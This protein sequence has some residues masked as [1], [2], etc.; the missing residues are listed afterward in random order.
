MPC[1]SFASARPSPSCSSRRARFERLAQ[2]PASA[3]ALIDPELLALRV[4]AEF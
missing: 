1:W 4:S 2:E 3:L